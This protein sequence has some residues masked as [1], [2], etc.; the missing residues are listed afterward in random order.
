VPMKMPTSAMVITGYWRKDI[1]SERG[2]GR[3]VIDS[4]ATGRETFEPVTLGYRVSSSQHR[5]PNRVSLFLSDAGND[6][7]IE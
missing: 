6:G 1:A 2:R 7:I 4:R 3:W 5:S